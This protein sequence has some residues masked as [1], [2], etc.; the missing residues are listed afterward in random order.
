M[1]RRRLWCE[2]G[3]RERWKAKT[4]CFKKLDNNSLGIL[5]ISRN[6][7]FD[8]WEIDKINNLVSILIQPINNALLYRQAI[9]N[10]SI[11]PITKLNNRMLFNKIIDQE[12]DFAKRH[13]QKLLLMKG[14]LP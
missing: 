11:D 10:A 1:S 2:K 14:N 6:T 9:T 5:V 12:I 13:N 4:Q 7:E 3:A 8:K